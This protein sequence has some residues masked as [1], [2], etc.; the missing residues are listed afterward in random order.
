MMR[1]DV[2]DEAR[3]TVKALKCS[4]TSANQQMELYRS[5]GW[6]EF[7]ISNRFPFISGKMVTID[8]PYIFQQ[9]FSEFL[10]AALVVRGFYHVFS[11]FLAIYWVL[12]NAWMV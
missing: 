1:N 3:A 4:K 10:S 12:W 5:E 6:K 11:H 2:F 7:N 8:V 9:S